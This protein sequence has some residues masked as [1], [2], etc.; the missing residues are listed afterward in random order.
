VVFGRS[1]F[2]A[3]AF[4]KGQTCGP[5]C[6]GLKISIERPPHCFVWISLVVADFEACRGT[7]NRM[8]LVYLFVCGGEE[9]SNLAGAFGP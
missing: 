6:M 9:T 7:F 5:S 8:V 3:C 4:T 1:W 2:L